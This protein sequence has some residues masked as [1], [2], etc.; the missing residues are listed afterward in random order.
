[1]TFSWWNLGKV[2]PK[3]KP[4]QL[5]S[6]LRPSDCP[7]EEKL[8]VKGGVLEPP[9][10]DIGVHLLE[11]APDHHGGV[12]LVVQASDDQGAEGG[13]PNLFKSHSYSPAERV[14]VGR[15]AGG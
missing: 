10:G 13:N 15:K 3:E 5:A 7:V 8:Q 14:V 2:K 6:V 4:P 12:L 9:D 1:M 11:V